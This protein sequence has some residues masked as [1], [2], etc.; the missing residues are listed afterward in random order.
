MYSILEYCKLS[1]HSLLNSLQF[2]PFTFLVLWAKLNLFTC[3]LTPLEESDSL[4]YSG[5]FTSINRVYNHMRFFGSLI[6]LA[7]LI[8][9]K[10]KKKRLR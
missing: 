6:I 2:V 5:C 8:S 4:L 10:Q 7:I 9:L 1:C 3:G